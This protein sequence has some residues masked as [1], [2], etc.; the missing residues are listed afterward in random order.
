MKSVALELDN[1]VKWSTLRESLL[2]DAVADYGSDDS[3]WSQILADE[4][5][6]KFV[7]LGIGER[8][9]KLKW[10][11]CKLARSNGFEDESSEEAEKKKA[12]KLKREARQLARSNA[13][14]R[15]VII[16][17][18]P[19]ALGIGKREP[20]WTPDLELMLKDAV[21]IH[22]EDH[23]D[24]KSESILKDVDFAPL[25]KWTH[26]ALRN[27]WGR[28]KKDNGWVRN[29]KKKTVRVNENIRKTSLDVPNSSAEP[30]TSAVPAVMDVPAVVNLLTAIF[31]QMVTANAGIK[32]IVTL[33][34]DRK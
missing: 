31:E 34:K 25:H 24:F 16:E 26:D 21:D 2:E 8:E 7:Y 32:E 23:A 30:G 27:K 12:Q 6:E 28:L 19:K 15:G 20:K 4:K 29:P 3:S 11:A 18:A 14:T 10:E 1:K 22:G 5:Y 9:L 17:K 13:G 33:L